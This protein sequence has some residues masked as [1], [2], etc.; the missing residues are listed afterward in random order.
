MTVPKGA[1]LTKH[2]AAMIE[3]ARQLFEEEGKTITETCE[4]LQLPKQTVVQWQEKEKWR[5]TEVKRR[6]LVTEQRVLLDPSVDSALKVLSQS[7]KL[8]RETDY[9]EK[10]HL[11]AC[12]VP[13]ILSHLSPD[14]TVAKADKVF[15]LIEAS[16][17]ILGRD[18][19]Q[20]GKGPLSLHLHANLPSR[21]V[22]SETIDADA[23]V[24][25]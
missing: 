17:K 21:M 16:R 8:Q 3:R 22:D 18:A 14:E 15:K 2:S 20:Q 24:V 25:T 1:T 12:S 13:V 4:I 11:W 10:L 23:Q 9:D 19:P 6:I 7:P 5:P